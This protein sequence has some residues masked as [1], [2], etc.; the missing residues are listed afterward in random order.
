ME[1]ETDEEMGVGNE[2][3]A[4]NTTVHVSG[5]RDLKKSG[6]DRLNSSESSVL[7]RDLLK[8]GKNNSSTGFGGSV[9]SNSAG[10]L[11][12]YGAGGM[13]GIQINSHSTNINSPTAT[14]PSSSS[15]SSNSIFDCLDMDLSG[16]PISASVQSSD[17]NLQMH[18]LTQQMEKESYFLAQQQQLLLNHQQAQSNNSNNSNNSNTNN[19]NNNNNPL[20]STMIESL[21]S[22]NAQLAQALEKQRLINHAQSNSNQQTMQQIQQNTQYSI[23]S[24]FPFLGMGM[25][26]NLSMG[27]GMGNM[28]MSNM[29]MNSPWR[30]PTGNDMSGNGVSAGI[31]SS[32]NLNNAFMSPCLDLGSIIDDDEVFIYFY[33]FCTLLI[34]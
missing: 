33:I 11:D 28:A 19:I 21:L 24:P 17:E 26:L 4:A 9:D 23:S 14:P 20:T 29:G 34:D 32:M 3:F 8:G 13:S 25:D 27:M 16:S 30:M 6:S 31:S 18:N 7:S 5:S 2:P 22:Q 10:L 12:Y 1:A 15:S